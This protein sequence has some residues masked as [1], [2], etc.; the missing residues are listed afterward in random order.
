MYTYLSGIVTYPYIY[1]YVYIRIIK[2][3]FIHTCAYVYELI[4]GSPA[5]IY[6][7]VLKLFMRMGIPKLIT[8]D[9]IMEFN[10]KLNSELMNIKHILTTAYHSQ[11]T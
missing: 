5:M 3:Y 2:P 4:E 6:F 1:V 7:F 10:N 8:S 11:V 9:Q